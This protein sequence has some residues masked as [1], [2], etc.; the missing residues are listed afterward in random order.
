MA[1]YN[2]TFGGCGHKGT[3]SLVGNSKARESRLSYLESHGTCSTCYA[4]AKKL[5][6]VQSEAAKAAK[7]IDLSPQ[8]ADLAGSE[9]QIAWAVK[10]RAEMVTGF[11][12][13][14]KPTSDNYPANVN[15]FLTQLKSD[16]LTGIAEQSSAKWFI[17]HRDENPSDLIR[18]TAKADFKALVAEI[19]KPAVNAE[20][21]RLQ[22]E[23]DDLTPQIEAAKTTVDEIVAETQP[24]WDRLN[25]EV[26]SWS[27]EAME[28][29]EWSDHMLK[30][31]GRKHQIEEL[32]STHS[33]D[34]LKREQAHL[35]SQMSKLKNA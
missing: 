31:V 4:A 29:D 13:T 11:A 16:I 19:N 2:I 20:I 12:E 28:A 34:A 7:A 1:N 30:T 26:A 22:A 9:K 5:E 32:Q 35:Q 6:R 33:L 17:D 21:A 23:I 10:I 24:E 8:L 3:V 25:A 27:D 15:A 18:P 14:I